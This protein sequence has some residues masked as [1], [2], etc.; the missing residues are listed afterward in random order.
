MEKYS[1]A[2]SEMYSQF[3]PREDHPLKK[4][5]GQLVRYRGVVLEVVGYS[6][7]PI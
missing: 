3:K 7:D 2:V 6:T 5:V 1:K 4:Y